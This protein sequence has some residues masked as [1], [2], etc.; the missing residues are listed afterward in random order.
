MVVMSATVATVAPIAMGGVAVTQVLMKKVS[1]FLVQFVGQ[2][3]VS[4]LLH[5]AYEESVPLQK[6]FPADKLV[7]V[8]RIVVH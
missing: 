8:P 3:M 7:P 4:D 5:S 6:Y 1:C 2:V